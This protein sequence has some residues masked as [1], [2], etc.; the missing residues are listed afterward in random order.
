M[1]SEVSPCRMA[2]SC[3]AGVLVAPTFGSTDGESL[4][5]M[6]GVSIAKW[7]SDRVNQIVDKAASGGARLGFLADH[8][9]LYPLPPSSMPF[10]L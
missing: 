10:G 6:A 9:R 8:F 1:K 7:W 2:A 5:L 3:E 4:A